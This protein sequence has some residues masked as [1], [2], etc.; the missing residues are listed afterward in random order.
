MSEIFWEFLLLGIFINNVYPISNNKYVFNN[1]SI[2][3]T[4]S[5]HIVYYNSNNFLRTNFSKVFNNCYLFKPFYVFNSNCFKGLGNFEFYTKFPLKFSI[6]F[7]MLLIE[8][9][10]LNLNYRS[11]KKRNSFVVSLVLPFTLNCSIHIT[12]LIH[13]YKFLN[14]CFYIFEDIIDIKLFL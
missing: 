8:R 11:D 14:Y 4:A 13:C 3:Y 12:K 9:L 5:N 2:A 10:N 6:V 7:R 1:T